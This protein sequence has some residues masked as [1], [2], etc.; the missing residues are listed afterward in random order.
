VTH[1]ELT[2]PPPVPPRGIVN[3]AFPD[4]PPDAAR[5]LLAYV[6]AFFCGFFSAFPGVD[7]GAITD[8]GEGG[9]GGATA[10]K[11]AG[12]W[13]GVGIDIEKHI[14]RFSELYVSLF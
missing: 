11:G 8:T 13:R 7:G 10:C 6:L 9:G 5:L 14:L 2:D 12:A 3:L 1:Y 4:I